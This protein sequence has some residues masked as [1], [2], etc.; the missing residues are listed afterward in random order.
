MSYSKPLGDRERALEDLFF[1]KEEA[2]AIEKL[3]ERLNREVEFEHLA[4][5]LGLRD[6]EIVNPLL[7]LGLREESV[8]A[9]IMAPLVCVAWADRTL[10]NE[11]RKELLKAE[12]ELGISPDSAAAE[13]LTTWLDHAPAET[14]LDTWV[15]YVKELPNSLHP[16]DLTRVRNDILSWSWR[17]AYSL[18]KSFLRGGASCE[19]ERAVIERIEEALGAPSKSKPDADGPKSS[20]VDEII[21]TMT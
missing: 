2:R 5:A 18:E 10:D 3:R 21:R 1:Q 15:A 13:L 14:L 9:L 19:A 11:E 8:T 17:I 7:K 16:D 12:A 6:S 4:N 20:G